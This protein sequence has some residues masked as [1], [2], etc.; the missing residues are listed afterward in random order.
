MIVNPLENCISC[1]N[2][3][4]ITTCVHNGQIVVA[5]IT[6][7]MKCGELY[8]FWHENAQI[9]VI[10]HDGYGFWVEHPKMGTIWLQWDDVHE[11]AM[12]PVE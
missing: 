12:F 7:C 2:D 5:M 4:I 6:E 8:T 1:E 9:M 10:G 11:M 3:D